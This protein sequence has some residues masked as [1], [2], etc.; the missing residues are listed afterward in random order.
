MGI[1]PFRP[2]ANRT[3]PANG[4]LAVIPEGA[5]VAFGKLVQDGIPAADALAAFCEQHRLA[6]ARYGSLAILA[7]P[8]ELPEHLKRWADVSGLLLPGNI[9]ALILSLTP[10]Q[11]GKHRDGGFV[12]VD[13]LTEAQRQLLSPLLPSYPIPLFPLKG[14]PGK[15]MER[16]EPTLD[17]PG[18]AFRVDRKAVLYRVKLDDDVAHSNTLFSLTTGREGGPGGAG[19]ICQFPPLAWRLRFDMREKDDPPLDGLDASLSLPEPVAVLSLRELIAKLAEQTGREFLID[20]RAAN[21]LIGIHGPRL[22]CKNLLGALSQATMMDCRD[23]DGAL[24]LGWT[25]QG[26]MRAG[27]EKADCLPAIAAYER[28]RQLAPEVCDRLEHHE[29]PDDV[30]FPVEW[31]KQFRCVRASEL[32]ED[33][34]EYV[35]RKF[36]TWAEKLTGQ[37]EE[38]SLIAFAVTTYIALSIPGFHET[39]FRLRL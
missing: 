5:E 15:R 19:H 17:T 36:T 27:Y 9:H 18:L 28:W 23:V 6:H 31:F 8:V 12:S 24:F 21:P 11:L 33:A 2:D 4:V 7:A 35:A 10:D 34:L 37:G 1:P 30:P 32:D 29:S 3:R 38:P 22:P 39:S 25:S 26:G 16:V 14:P 20:R 13:G